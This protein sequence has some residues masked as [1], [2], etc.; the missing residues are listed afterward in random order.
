MECPYCKSR[1]VKKGHFMEC[2]KCPYS[3]LYKE[4]KKIFDEPTP[5][6]EEGWKT[7]EKASS[8]D[9]AASVII[10]DDKP[11]TITTASGTKKLSVDEFK[12]EFKVP[13]QRILILIGL[14]IFVTALNPFALFIFVPIITVIIAIYIVAMAVKRGFSMQR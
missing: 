4:N 10:D 13:T 14:L 5:A 1:L 6:D 8:Y 3:V 2:P 11:I 7:V 9:S 12:E